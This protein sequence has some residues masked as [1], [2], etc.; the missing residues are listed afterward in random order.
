MADTRYFSYV[1]Q[2]G[3][4][5]KRATVQAMDERSVR[6]ILRELGMIPIEIKRAKPKAN[7][8]IQDPSSNIGL[9]IVRETKQAYYY[10][11]IPAEGG[12]DNVRGEVLASSDREARELLRQRGLIPSTVEPKRLWHDL[13]MAGRVTTVAEARMQA[14]DTQN[15]RPTGLMAQL[16]RFFTSK[17]STK[18]IYFYASQL[19]TMNEAGLSFSQSMDILSGLITHPRMLVIHEVVRSKVM[20]GSSLTE[21]Y[22]LFEREL[23]RIFTEL[24]A[25]GEAS[26]NLEA[27]LQRMVGYLEKSMELMGKVKGALTYPIILLFIIT[28]IVLGLMVFV[29]PTFIKLFES[30][31]VELPP[32]TA[33]LIN[34][35]NYIMHYGYTLPLFPLSIWMIWKGIMSTKFG[36]QM[37]DLWEYRIPLFGKLIYKVMIARLLHNLALF[38]SCG[39]TILNALEMTQNSVTNAYT[40][41]KL[42]GIRV[43]ISQGARLSALFEGSG[44]FPPIVNYLLIAGEESG[45]IDEL[46]E[47]GGKYMDKEVDGAIKALTAAIEPLLTVT[48][49]GVVLFVVGSLYLPLTSLMK[50]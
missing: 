33:A 1:A 35:S 28:L 18:E 41:V 2:E 5:I 46:L 20:E 17:I 23:P 3:N 11:A 50:G 32:T 44:L 34:I 12:G 24:I 45:A 30:F 43:G 27:T 13:L 10:V 38:L 19:A 14:K 48:V 21:A 26:G 22:G 6:A 4:S 9:G 7:D 40:S 29:V 36:R 39:I 25:V 8:T 16:S 47:R 15:R 31:K 49:A 37:Y 42:E